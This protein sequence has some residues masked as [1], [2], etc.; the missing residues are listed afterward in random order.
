[1][2]HIRLDDGWHRMAPDGLE[3]ACGVPI[4]MRLQIEVRPGRFLE[5][6]LAPPLSQGGRCECW[7]TRERDKASIAYLARWGTDY[8]PWPVKP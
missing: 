6:P 5:H 3:T 2:S 8:K 7:T 1:M 4:D